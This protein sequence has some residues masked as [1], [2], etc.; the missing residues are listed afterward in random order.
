MNIKFAVSV[1][2]AKFDNSQGTTVRRA[3]LQK[4]RIFPRFAV[5]LRG[6]TRK[7][8][9][10]W[11]GV[12]ERIDIFPFEIDYYRSGLLH[13]ELIFD[14]GFKWSKNSDAN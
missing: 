9:I 13:L 2:N 7:G 14:N 10:H 3:A 1:N 8:R 12:N 5:Q 11:R 6:C 4:P